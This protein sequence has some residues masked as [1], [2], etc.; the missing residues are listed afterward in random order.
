MTPRLFKILM[1]FPAMVLIALTA[2][3]MAQSTAVT[4]PAG[5]SILLCPPHAGAFPNQ[6]VIQS[7]DKKNNTTI[8]QIHNDQTQ[9]I[10]VRACMRCGNGIL[11][12]DIGEQCDTGGESA[13]CNAN[14]TTARCGDGI[15]NESA[16]EE[17]DDG[18]V[19][20]GDGCSSTCQTEVPLICGNGIL[21]AGEECDDGNRNNNDFCTNACKNAICGDGILNTAPGSTEQCDPPN[22]GTCDATCRI[23]QQ[24]CTPPLVNCT[25]ACV[26][27]N[28][29]V[30]NCGMC[31][32]VCGSNQ[33]C[34]SGQ[35]TGQTQC[36]PPLV[37]CTGACVDTSTSVNNCGMCGQICGASPN[38]T[39][40]CSNSHCQ[41]AVCNSGFADCNGN[42]ADGCEVNVTSDVKNCGAC[43]NA[44]SSNQTC[45][46]GQ[47]TGG[48]QCGM[49]QPVTHS[50][51][52]GQTWTDCTALGTYTQTQ[53]TA[54]C[55]A[56]T[57]S[58]SSCSILPCANSQVVCSSTSCWAYSGTGQ[59]HVSTSGQACPISADPSWQ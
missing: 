17:C 29:S 53:A 10:A 54:A 46:S 26:D 55:T 57:G 49:S 40:G 6:P 18:N 38:A 58:A 48:T 28:T 37:N 11:E 59:G 36:T 30:N 7:T 9:V 27:T 56:S 13:H 41:I 15:L 25:G 35:C 42:V 22:G 3:V 5:Q 43:G 32:H 23:A 21:Q 33:T 31:G 19:V 14:C 4:P 50:N 16:G 12:R 20:S 8:D 39:A 47:C 52:L 34:A 2:P 1:L 44:C 45:A 24:Q 51:G